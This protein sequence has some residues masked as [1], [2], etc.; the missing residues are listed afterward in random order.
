MSDWS[1]IGP[2]ECIRKSRVLF[3]KLKKKP[4]GRFNKIYRTGTDAVSVY[5]RISGH[6][7]PYIQPYM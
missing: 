6:T 7:R 1:Y 2:F 4:G 3:L 5:D